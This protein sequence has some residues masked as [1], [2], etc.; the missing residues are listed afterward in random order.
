MLAAALLLAGTACEVKKSSNP[1]SPTVAGPIPGVQITAPKMIDPSNGAR[2]EV[3][4]Q[5]IT[6]TIENAATNGVRPL[7]YSFDVATD[8][9]FTNK[10]YSRDNVTPG[11]GRTSVKLPDPLATG[12]TYYWRARAQDGANTGAFAATARFDVFT[13]IV[14]NAP[15]LV[16]PAPNEI[17]T[18]VRP[19]FTVTNATHTGPVGPINYLIELADSSTFA[20]KVG[21]TVA[22]QPGQTS[23]DTPQDLP[24]GKVLYWHVKAY[25]P[26][27]QG[28]FSE[29]RSFQTPVAPPPGHNPSPGPGVPSGPAPNDAINLGLA[30]IENSPADVASWPATATITSLDLGN[31]GAAVGFTKKDGPGSWPDVPFVTPGETLQYTLWIVLKING[32]WY[33]SGCIQFWR[34]L[35]RNGGPPSQYGQN[36]YY[37][38]VRWGPMAGYQPSNGEQ[39]GF[40]VTA[41]DA[42]NNGNVV[43]KER[44][45]VVVVPFPT[46]GGSFSFTTGRLPFGR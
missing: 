9:G 21:Q 17:L 38:P 25:D 13:P 39:V 19:R 46:N 26:T 7:W 37:D 10:V 23:F 35:G 32:Q 30:I 45:N 27:T 11:E 36:W 20:N 33:A 28:P 6:L 8:A 34:G 40:L 22:E 5:P 29:T 1:L 15:V 4:K 18:T 3:D 43:V 41:G 31:G 16:A 44:S 14:I 12:R 2:V 24:F 42:R